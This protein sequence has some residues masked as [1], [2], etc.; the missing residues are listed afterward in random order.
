VRGSGGV[1]EREA[2]AATGRGSTP[3]FGHVP[4][5]DGLRG[6]AVA[7]VLA[8]HLGR[9]RGGYLGVDLFFVLSGYLITSLLLVEFA[10]SGRIDRGAFW[11]R[12][13]RRLLPALLVVLVAVA[14]YAHWLARP[15]DRPGIRWDALATLGYVANWRSIL[16]GVSYWDISKA[17]SPL[18]HTWSLAIEEQFYLLWPLAVWAVA[19]LVRGS[20]ARFER[21]IGRI[22]I[23]GTAVGFGLFVGLHALGM[24]DQRVYQGTDTRAGALFAG[25]ALAVWATRRR[26]QA[27]DDAGSSPVWIVEAVGVAA[28]VLLGVL[29]VR[30]DGWSPW[31]YR[32]LLPVASLAAV[33]VVA[34][35]ADPRSPVLGRIL[36][37]APLRRLGAISY[38]LYLWHW[39]VFQAVDLRRGDLPGLGE[40]GHEALLIAWKLGLSLLF[41]TVSYVLVEQPIRRGR[42]PRRVRVPLALVAVLAV[43][44]L[45]LVSTRTTVTGPSTAPVAE[46]GRTIAR[47]PKVL[48]VGDSVAQSLA[49][50]IVADTPAFGI[51]VVNRTLLG[52]QQVGVGHDRF[53]ADGVTPMVAATPCIGEVADIARIR[54]DVVF[55]DLGATPYELIEI[56]GVK[57]GVCD[58][59]RQEL[60]RRT[61]IEFVDLLASTGAKVGLA[62]LMHP[63]NDALPIPHADELIDCANRGVRAVVDSDPRTFLVDLDAHVCPGGAGTCRQEIDGATVRSDGMHFDN[64]PGGAAVAHWVVEQLLRH[65]PGR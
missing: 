38:G 31:L 27:V 5:L 42:L 15:I 44:A 14:A 57:R 30:L 64:T 34:A 49:R 4:G 32:G 10:R 48:I 54:P 56:D 55:L 40:S 58:P 24:S 2:P 1:E 11:S 35:V 17:P 39:P 33:G 36:S 50:P 51:N 23:V 22:A 12:R 26:A 47:A 7:A 53:Q 13:V 6:A 3:G 21:A 60:Y 29:W 37:F 45:V 65:V 25:V 18:Q 59:V 46:T 43:V 16:S 63:G 9:L 8:Y 62:T 19:R 61:T 41:A 28:A 52:C 20:Q